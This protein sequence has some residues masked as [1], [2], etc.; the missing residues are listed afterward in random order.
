MMTA[1]T[2]RDV[3]DLQT[4]FAKQRFDHLVAEGTKM[5]EM[6]VKVAN[7]AMEPLQKQFDTTVSTPTKPIAL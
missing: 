3:I 4:D 6:S 2:M 5:S 1:K 7:E